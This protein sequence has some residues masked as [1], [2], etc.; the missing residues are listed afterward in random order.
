MSTP[1]ITVIMPV[2]NGSKYLKFAIE[3]IFNQTYKDFELIIINDGSTDDS[4]KIIMSYHDNRLRYYSQSNI[5]LTLTL[6]KLIEYARGK[7]LARMDQDDWSHPRRLERQV[8]FLDSHPKVFLLGSWIQVIDIE[9]KI[10]YNHKYPVTNQAIKEGMLYSNCFAHGSVMIRKSPEI[11]YRKE[12]DDAEDMDLWARICQRYEVGNLPEY[13][14]KWRVNPEGICLSRKS[15]QKNTVNKI[16][17]YYRPNYL[18]ILSK[19]VITKEEINKEIGATGRINFIKRKLNLWRL[20]Y[21]FRQSK[22]ALQQLK[23]IINVF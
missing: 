16:L 12:F 1:Q 19:K 10:R 23:E 15:T 20:F 17:S 6:N 8:N 22:I 13:L 5:G 18:N 11:F 3:S 4:E 7:Y 21:N 14:Y 2:Y 9:G